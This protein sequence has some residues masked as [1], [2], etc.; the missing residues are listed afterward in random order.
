MNNTDLRIEIWVRRLSRELGRAQARQRVRQAF[1]RVPVVLP[2]KPQQKKLVFQG[3]LNK[4]VGAVHLISIA[5][6]SVNA[7]TGW[8]SL[9]QTSVR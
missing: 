9:P 2:S 8:V 7:E 6:L 5:M 1:D 3:Q 4:I